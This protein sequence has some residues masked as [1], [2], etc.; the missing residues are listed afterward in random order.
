MVWVR[1]TRAGMQPVIPAPKAVLIDPNGIEEH[2]L[3]SK[4][5]FSPPELLT[6]GERYQF[7]AEAFYTYGLTRPVA[8]NEK[9]RAGSLPWDITTV[10]ANL[11]D[12]SAN[13][14]DG[15]LI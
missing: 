13:E 8:D 12:R 1:A 6:D 3:D 5:V 2:L 15:E 10:Q 7:S 11:F 9:Y 14:T 4:V